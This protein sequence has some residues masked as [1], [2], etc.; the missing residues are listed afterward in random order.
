MRPR[1]PALSQFE[2]DVKGEDAHVTVTLAWNEEAYSGE[3]NGSAEP[4]ARPRLIGEAT[5][6]AVEKISEGKLVLDLAA[7]ATTDH[8]ASRVAIAQVTS[9]SAPGSLVG[10]AVIHEDNPSK[11]TARAVLDAVNRHLAQAL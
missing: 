4:H 3:S 1:R 8:G 5:L 10:S 7:V 9:N 6:R 11:A 2:E